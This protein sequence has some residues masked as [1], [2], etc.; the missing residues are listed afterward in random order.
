MNSVPRPPFFLPSDLGFFP[1]LTDA[2]ASSVRDP[3]GSRAENGSG[4]DDVGSHNG[5]EDS[6]VAVLTS[7]PTAEGGA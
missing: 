6:V 7:C 3:E 1:V 2:S 4:S 5:A